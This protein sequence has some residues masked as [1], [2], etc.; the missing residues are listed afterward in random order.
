MNVSSGLAFVP[1]PISPVYCAAK[2]GLHSYT[3]S[4]RVQLQR[5]AVKVFELAPPLTETP[6][7][8]GFDP[9]DMEGV[10][11]MPVAVLAKAAIDGLAKDDFEIRPGQA[12]ALKLMSRVAP[13]FILKQLSKGVDQMLARQAGS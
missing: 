11:A 3:Q 6:L 8:G 9:K 13:G 10:P 7:L 5:S 2:A 4:L 1:F 12:N